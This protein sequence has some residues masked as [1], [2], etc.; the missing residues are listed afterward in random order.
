MYIEI[1]EKQREIINS[2]I[3]RAGTYRKLSKKIDIPRASLVRYKQEGAIPEDRF[4]RIIGF[5]GVQESSLKTRKL[6]DNWRQKTGGLK[7]VKIKKKKG[8]FE[9]QLKR[10]Q[11]SGAK[12]LKSWH[13]RMKKE[14]PQEYYSIQYEKFKKIYGYKFLTKKGEKVRN[15]LEKD[16]ADMLIKMKINY[17]Y[18]KLVNVEKRWFFPDFVI[19]GKIIIECTAWKGETKAYQLLEKIEYYN[20]AKYTTFVV[21]PKH[22]YRKYKVLDK[23]L[24]LGVEGLARVAQ[25]VRARGC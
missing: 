1:K 10:A 14:S 22:L 16:V 13:Q 21:I 9:D 24:I 19:D 18:E 4:S 11:M 20:K 25:L 6:E 2:A 3:K 8:T 23:H 5:L 7:C 15:K 17:D 12:K